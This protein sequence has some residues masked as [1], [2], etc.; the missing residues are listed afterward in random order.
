[1]VDLDGDART[2]RPSPPR[3]ETKTNVCVFEDGETSTDGVMSNR[4]FTLTRPQMSCLLFISL[5][6]REGKVAVFH[7][8]FSA[9]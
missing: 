4:G 5:K 6:I 8:Y 7:F 9:T 1:M 2:R 3:F